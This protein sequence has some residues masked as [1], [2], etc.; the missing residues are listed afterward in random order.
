MPYMIDKLLNPTAGLIS[1]L[2]CLVGGLIFLFLGHIHREAE[3]KRTG[4][5]MTIISFIAVGALIGGICGAIWVLWQKKHA[6]E[7]A[8]IVATAYKIP[9]ATAGHNLGLRHHTGAL[10]GK[11]PA[12]KSV[13]L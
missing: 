12:G 7:Q 9:V 11:C 6:G 10:L 1:A 4:V 8:P 13:N 3:E 5:A 2:I